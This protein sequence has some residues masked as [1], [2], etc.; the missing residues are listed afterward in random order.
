[1]RRILATSRT[2]SAMLAAAALTAACGTMGN[3]MHGG[4]NEAVHLTGAQEVPPV[5]TNASG[6][7]HIMVAS[8]KTVQ[9]DV[10]TENIVGTA[11]HIH[12]GAAG[13]NGPVIVPLK[14]TG[15]NTWS[16][17]AG[18]MLNDSQYAA[19]KEGKLYVNVHSAGHPGG[20][21]RAQLSPY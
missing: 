15:D 14:K 9:G 18:S 5:S 11:A 6:T 19:Y 4:A 2:L 13:T 17:P 21:I 1:M 7:G 16:V 8:D 12:I 3:M 20:E 10:T